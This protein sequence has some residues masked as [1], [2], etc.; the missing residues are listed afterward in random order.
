MI[1]F[2]FLILLDLSCVIESRFTNITIYEDNPPKLNLFTILKQNFNCLIIV[3]FCL[4]NLYELYLS[5]SLIS[6][7]LCPYKT[8]L[9]IFF[10]YLRIKCQNLRLNEF[11]RMI[12][13][14]NVNSQFN[15]LSQIGSFDLDD[16]VKLN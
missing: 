15:K 11:N 1:F 8:W 16:N 4:L 12:E 6:I 7:I 2:Q 9:L 3:F 14:P 10:I 13:I 5:Y